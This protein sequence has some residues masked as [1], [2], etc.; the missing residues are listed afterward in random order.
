[1]VIPIIL[2]RPYPQKS[3]RPSRSRP[4]LEA[5][6]D[7]TLLSVDVLSR[8]PGLSFSDDPRYQPP[9]PSAA[10]GPDFIVETVNAS[11]EFF[12]KHTGAPLFSQQLEDFF[13]PVEPGYFVFDPVVTYD[14][15]AGRFFVGALEGRLESSFLDFAIS[16]T[17]NPLDGFTDMHRIR[18]SQTDPSGHPLAGDYP[19]LGF[20]A[21]AYV[22]TVNMLRT[23]QTH[24]HV[25]VV[26]IDKSSVLDK[27]PT[28]LTSYQVNRP[29]PAIF[30]MAPATMHGS[31]PGGP[32]YFVVETTRSGGESL[33][34][35]QMTDMLTASPIFTDRDVPVPSYSSPPWAVHPEGGTIDTFGSFIL[36]ADWR[37]N[38]LVATHHVGSDA[39]TR[40]RWYEFDTEGRTPILVQSGEIN[41]GPSVYTYFSAIAV[42]AN[43]DMGLTFME[44]SA[45]EF[46][47]MYIT[48]RKASDAPGT[49]QTPVDVFPGERAYLGGVRGGDYSSVTVDPVGDTFWATNMY[50]PS[51][52]FW[53]TGIANFVITDATMPGAPSPGAVSPD[54]VRERFGRA[55]ANQSFGFALAAIPGNQLR[56]FTRAG[57]DVKTDALPPS[58]QH[59]V[60]A[61]MIIHNR[62]RS[63]HGFGAGKVGQGASD[64][65]DHSPHEQE[66]F[67]T[68]PEG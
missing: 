20:N 64:P 46:V 62:Q 37:G 39:V 35:V 38:Q 18:L 48:G 41:Q 29:D 50:K 59:A 47:S 11:L 56:Q 68:F 52:S 55:N 3:L 43:G 60:V 8:W 9:D 30:T 24:D 28:T 54:A 7:R 31:A 57:Q 40:V 49:M 63:L 33:R 13:A 53:G 44:S 34:V 14:E 21:D 5:L 42:A 4:H 51:Y 1:V 36:N 10:V 12:E 22:V 15:M 17:S 66:H 16:N 6:E 23:D 45:T 27:D 25:Q 61:E 65:E 2:Q 19:K 58:P 67:Q 26:T 32:M